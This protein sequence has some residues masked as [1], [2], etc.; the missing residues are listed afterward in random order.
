MYVP[1]PCSLSLSLSLSRSIG[2]SVVDHALASEW[3]WVRSRLQPTTELTTN[4]PLSQSLR[5][6]LKPDRETE[7][8]GHSDLRSPCPGIIRLAGRTAGKN[9]SSQSEAARCTPGALTG[10]RARSQTGRPDSRG[11]QARS[12][13]FNVRGKMRGILDNMYGIV[14]GAP[15][16][17]PWQHLCTLKPFATCMAFVARLKNKHRLH[18]REMGWF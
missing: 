10:P 9:P 6:N 3:T 13:S 2:G 11:V 5:G 4:Q 18:V 7:I 1:R 17:H 12:L 15:V 14:C 8:T 16:W